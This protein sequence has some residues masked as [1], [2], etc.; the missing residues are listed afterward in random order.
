MRLK[1]RWNRFNDL[2]SRSFQIAADDSRLICYRKKIPARNGVEDSP[3][4]GYRFIKY[5]ASYFR[6][7][8]LRLNQ[9]GEYS[10]INSS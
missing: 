8:F 1:R 5:L 2:L 3:E 9:N 10:Q 7:F 6:A 4:A